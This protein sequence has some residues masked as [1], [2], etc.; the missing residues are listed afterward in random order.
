MSNRL[1]FV[2]VLVAAL[3]AWTAIL[4]RS[5]RGSEIDWTP[6]AAGL[7]VLVSAFSPHARGRARPD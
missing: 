2:L 7:L 3:L 4:I 6:L 1:A 5:V